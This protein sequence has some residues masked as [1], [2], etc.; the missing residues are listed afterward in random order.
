MEND[1][2]GFILRNAQSINPQKIALN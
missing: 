2:T 1:S